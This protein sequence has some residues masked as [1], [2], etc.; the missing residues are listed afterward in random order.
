MP[1]SVVDFDDAI[2]E[3]RAFYGP[4]PQ[5]PHEPFALYVWEV[6]NFHAAPLKREAALAA[7]RRIPALTPDS[8]WK[9]PLPKLEAAAGLAGPYLDER[10][11]ALRAG[12][13]VFRRRPEMAR[14][15]AGPALGAMR[16]LRALPQLSSAGT[17]RMLLYAASVPVIPVDAVTARVVVR[18]GWCEPHPDVRRQARRVRRALDK[19]VPRD[20][21]VRRR[22]AQMLEHHGQATCAE[23]DPHCGIC[24]LAARC[25]H[26]AAKA[27]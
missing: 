11:R 15:I 10:V 4:Q 19:I 12:A 20:I 1:R 26:N 25:A 6:M 9:T 17:S 16:A 18:L 24:P 3:L 5:P 2:R 27:V 22:V 23:F 13:D 7:L 21:E 8:I 14:A